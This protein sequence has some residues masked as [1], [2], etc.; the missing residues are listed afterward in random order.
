MAKYQE[1]MR[2]TKV[3][4]LYEHLEAVKNQ[5]PT[6]TANPMQRH[7]EMESLHRDIAYYEQALHC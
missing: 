4:K 3:D 6:C 7:Q 1:V 5:K 2:M